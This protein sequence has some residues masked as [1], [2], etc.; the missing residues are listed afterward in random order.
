M[1]E[2][3]ARAPDSKVHNW[4]VYLNGKYVAVHTELAIDLPAAGQTAKQMV[5]HPVDSVREAG[6]FYAEQFKP[7]EA[8]ALKL[9]DEALSVYHS[10]REWYDTS[11]AVKFLKVCK[12]GYDA[13]TAGADVVKG[14]QKLE[15]AGPE[16]EALASAGGAATGGAATAV[17]ALLTTTYVFGLCSIML[18]AITDTILFIAEVVQANTAEDIRK[19]AEGEEKA[20]RILKVVDPIGGIHSI[21]EAS[22]NLKKWEGYAK[23]FKALDTRL[24]P[25]MKRLEPL[26]KVGERLEK[27]LH[28]QKPRV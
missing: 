14:F 19:L 6:N 7:Y 23:K 5:L 8:E 18:V 4:L 13:W 28:D 16:A 9:R 25:L 27:W 2:T 22:E 17:V 3:A 11:N 15:Q 20:G 1:A 26:E 21:E 24:Q 10:V 12:H